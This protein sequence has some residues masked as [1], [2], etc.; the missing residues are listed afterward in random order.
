MRRLEVSASGSV[1]RNIHSEFYLK[2]PTPFVEPGITQKMN[3][4]EP[5]AAE[6]LQHSSPGSAEK[7]EETS[8]NNEKTDESPVVDSKE[9]NYP[10]GF[11]LAT[12]TASLM[13]AVFCVAL[14]NTV[15]IPTVFWSLRSFLTPVLDY[16]N[17]HTKDH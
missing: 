11:K 9:P 16:R 14:D 12:I 5:L 8:V 13:L 17:S 15:G 2:F 6:A 7:S 4:G 3:S 1:F 10:H